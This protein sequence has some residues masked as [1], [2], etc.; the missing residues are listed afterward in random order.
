DGGP[1]RIEAFRRLSDPASQRFVLEVYALREDEWRR[2]PQPPRILAAASENRDDLVDGAPKYGIPFL[3]K[4]PVRE[5]PC[6]LFK[7]RPCPCN[8]RRIAHEFSR[9]EPMHDQLRG[10][11]CGLTVERRAH[12]WGRSFGRYIISRSQI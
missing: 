10:V 2:Q 3:H 4:G 5:A 6:H 9:D 7:R 11:V 12:R 8:Q 1:T